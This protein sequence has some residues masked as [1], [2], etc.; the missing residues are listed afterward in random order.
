MLVL[1]W[2]RNCAG[3]GH[4]D[5]V[6]D[7]GPKGLSSPSTGGRTFGGVKATKSLRTVAFGLAGCVLLVAA[8]SAAGAVKGSAD[9]VGICHATGDPSAPYTAMDVDW[10]AADGSAKK[11]AS[12]KDLDR[13]HF[14]QSKGSGPVAGALWKAGATSW[15]DIIPAPS[16]PPKSNKYGNKNVIGW[17]YTTAGKAILDNN[18]QVTATSPTTTTTPATTTTSVVDPQTGG[19]TTTTT[20]ATTTTSSTT[21]TTRAT[22]TTSSTTTTRATTTTSVVGPNQGGVTTTTAGAPPTTWNS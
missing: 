3:C 8:A 18:C 16:K 6:W 1:Q 12:R 11:V 15:G 2:S 14:L 19:T 21:T 20:R 13:D 10:A 9:T 4:P 17:N 7:R 22:T 5:G